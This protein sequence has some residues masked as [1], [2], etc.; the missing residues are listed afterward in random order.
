MEGWT[1]PSPASLHVNVTYSYP[2]QTVVILRISSATK[3]SKTKLESRPTL[4]TPKDMME[5]ILV[6]NLFV[7][8]QIQSSEA[9]KIRQLRNENTHRHPDFVDSLE[10][11]EKWVS[12]ENEQQKLLKNLFFV[13]KECYYKHIQAMSMLR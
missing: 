8:S 11:I 10:L 7:V 12:S 13:S 6:G 9:T 2:Q 1:A 4:Q 5:A 3:I